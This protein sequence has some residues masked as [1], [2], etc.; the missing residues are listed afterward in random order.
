MDQCLKIP[1]NIEQLLPAVL[2]WLTSSMVYWKKED[3]YEKGQTFCH[4]IVHTYIV[5]IQ[6][7]IVW[8][9]YS[10]RIWDINTTIVPPTTDDNNIVDPMH[11]IIMIIIGLYTKVK[12][13]EVPMI[14]LWNYLQMFISV[15]C[16]FFVNFEIFWK[17]LN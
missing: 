16:Q 9:P 13:S 8:S 2:P 10:G 11:S 5:W 3:K 15:V 7:S 12:Y 1:N 17:Y 4:V 14:W 6:T